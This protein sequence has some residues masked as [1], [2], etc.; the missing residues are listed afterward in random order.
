VSNIDHQ[1]QP[2]GATANVPVTEMSPHAAQARLI[3]DAMKDRVGDN[4]VADIKLAVAGFGAVLFALAGGYLLLDNKISRLA[5]RIDAQSVTIT[6]IET[7]L[8]DLIA[9][10]PPVATPAP[11]R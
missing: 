5:E 7:K 2:P 4:R 11:R 8:D 6:R 10:I 1:G 3:A 9:R